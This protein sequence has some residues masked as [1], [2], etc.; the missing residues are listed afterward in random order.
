MNGSS[1]ERGWFV[2]SNNDRLS[3]RKVGSK[4]VHVNAG[5]QPILRTGTARQSLAPWN[6]VQ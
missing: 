1:P 4:R 5:A 6:S 3:G 2:I